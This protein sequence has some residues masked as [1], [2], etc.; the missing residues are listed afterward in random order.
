[1]RM[2]NASDEEL[3]LAADIAQ[4]SEFIAE[5]PEGLQAEIAQG[6]MNVS[7]GQKQRLAI[8]RAL[9]KKAAHLHLRRQLLR[10]RLQDRCGPAQ[11]AQAEYRR[12]HAC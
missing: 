7:G 6:G 5:K 9:V 8:A 3:K 1:M 2:K 11:G 4:A 10:A 12:Q